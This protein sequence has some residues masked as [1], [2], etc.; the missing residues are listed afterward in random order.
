MRGADAALV[1]TLIDDKPHV[2]LRP[3]CDALGIDADTQARK[4]KSRSWATTVIRTVVAADGKAREML[5]IDRRTMTMWLAT[6]DENRVA[7]SARP[8]VRAFQAE[9]ADA[10]DAYFATGVA[11]NPRG[12]LSTFDVLRAQID[13]IEAAHRTAEEA[14]AIAAKTDARLDAIEGRHDWYSALGYARLHK[15]ENTSTRFLNQVGR[16]A[17]AI[18]AAHGI[19]PVKVPHALYGE[20]NSLPAWVWE[21]AFSGRDGAA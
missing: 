15:I 9:A 11:V 4:L 7:E 8:V 21:R 17:S 12:T 3:M 5:M 16:Q 14:K 13:Q 2:A 6:I 1:A 19:R 20:V 18:A 10:L